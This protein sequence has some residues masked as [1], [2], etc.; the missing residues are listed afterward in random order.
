M[1][2]DCYQRKLLR[3]CPE[4]CDCVHCIYDD[5]H[6]CQDWGWQYP[7]G[8]F[9]NHYNKL[10]DFS[11]AFNSMSVS[12]N[13]QQ[14]IKSNMVPNPL[15]KFQNSSQTSDNSSQNTDYTNN[16]NNNVDNYHNSKQNFTI[17]PSTQQHQQQFNQ[18]DS[19]T[20]SSN[21][22]EARA[23]NVMT[24]AQISMSNTAIA[25]TCGAQPMDC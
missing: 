17:D 23:D 20:N 9:E 15:T 1:C 2:F 14:V 12:G 22:V 25:S 18:M 11:L 5:Y 24:D 13:T 8:A 19:D 10:D 7:Q 21:M 16:C 3:N 4:V 6:R